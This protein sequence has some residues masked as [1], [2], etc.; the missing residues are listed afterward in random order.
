M[1]GDGSLQAI[2]ASVPNGRTATCWLAVTSD[3]R[4]AYT[5]NNGSA[6]ISS[7]RVGTDG[8]PPADLGRRGRHRFAPVDLVVSD[9]GRY[10]YNVNAGDGTVGAYAIRA[11]STSSPSPST[12]SSPYPTMVGPSTRTKAEQP[13]SLAHPATTSGG[14]GWPSYEHQARASA[15]LGAHDANLT[16][17]SKPEGDELGP[18]RPRWRHRHELSPPG[19]SPASADHARPQPHMRL[20][21]DSIVHPTRRDFSGPVGTGWSRRSSYRHAIGWCDHLDAIVPSAHDEHRRSIRRRTTR[22]KTMN[23]HTTTP[24][25][26]ATTASPAPHHGPIGR[27]RQVLLALLAALLAGGLMAACGERNDNDQASD[28]PTSET[29]GQQPLELSL[30]DG[31][32]MASCL[33]VDAETLSQMAPAFRGTVTAVEGETIT[34]DI[35]TWYAGADPVET[36]QLHADQG[37]EALIGGIDFRVDE[38]YLI[39]AADGTV[40]YCGYSGPAEPTLTALFE[41]AFAS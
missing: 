33:A 3:G 2:R 32:A 36:V 10:L 17:M 9:N 41:E 30:G 38:E 21:P 40:N 31:G 11:S 24:G 12:H 37:L 16:R 1:S 25:A 4:F 5:T 7:Y 18:T 34:L 15:A 22:D 14:T 13:G 29:A 23:T 28:T 8:D 35:D 27:A 39:T 6:S 26:S 20:V 19:P